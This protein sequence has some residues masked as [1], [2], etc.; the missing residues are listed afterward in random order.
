MQCSMG[1][2]EEVPPLDDIGVVWKKTLPHAA[3]QLVLQR[4]G[5]WHKELA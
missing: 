5:N 2:E 3:R 4:E 1:L